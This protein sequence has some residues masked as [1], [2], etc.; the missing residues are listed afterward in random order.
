MM[1]VS[2]RASAIAPHFEFEQA[3]SVMWT[4]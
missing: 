4:I 1:S 2:T 3:P